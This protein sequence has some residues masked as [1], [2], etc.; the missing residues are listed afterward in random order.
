MIDAE[1]SLVLFLGVTPVQGRL[2]ETGANP[3]GQPRRGREK[4]EEGHREGGK[5][6]G[7][8]LEGAVGV[9]QAGG[10][11]SR[12]GVVVY[13]IDQVAEGAGLGNGVRVQDYQVTARSCSQAE[14][15]GSAVAKVGFV[16]NKGC[17]VG[18]GCV[19]RG[20]GGGVVNH[21]HFEAQ[22]VADRA[23]EDGPKAIRE[24]SP[25]IPTDDDDADIGRTFRSGGGRFVL[26]VI[27][28]YVRL[29][30]IYH[31]STTLR[32]QS[33]GAVWRI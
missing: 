27:L 6:E 33:S 18:A 13:K 7:G 17:I 32:M 14:I 22:T 9:E 29:S 31:L 16:A 24:V 8:V 20:V 11:N 4:I 30:H 12:V 2:E 21:Y 23:G 28:P 15:I 1:G 19:R 25:D 5:A 3:A 10:N 26:N